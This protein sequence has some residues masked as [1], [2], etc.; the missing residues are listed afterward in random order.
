MKLFWGVLLFSSFAMAD[1]ATY[2]V[3]GMHCGSC[4]KSI[5]T[6]VCKMEGVKSCKAEVTDTKNQI[7]KLTVITE[8]GKPIDPSKV[9]ELVS[10]AGSYT[11]DTKT[12]EEKK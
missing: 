8:D 3:K 2:Q 11:I 9:A 5:E 12:K 4:A 1:T 6:S 10:A 7:G